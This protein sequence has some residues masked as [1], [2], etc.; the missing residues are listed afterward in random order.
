[1]N[2]TIRSSQ[3][4]IMG[5]RSAPR[6]WSQSSTASIKLQLLQFSIY[7]IHLGQFLDCGLYNSYLGTVVVIE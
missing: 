7:C 5:A 4:R 2:P 3:A 6:C 1:M